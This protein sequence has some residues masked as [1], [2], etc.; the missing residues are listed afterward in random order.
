MMAKARDART[1]KKDA[2]V[3]LINQTAPIVNDGEQAVAVS[4]RGETAPSNG[5][6]HKPPGYENFNAVVDGPDVVAKSFSTADV[7]SGLKLLGSP[8]RDIQDIPILADFPDKQYL[9]ACA[10]VISRCRIYE[11]KEGEAEV[12]YIVTGMCG[13]GGKRADLI[14]KAIVG[15]TSTTHGISGEWGKF[16]EKFKQKIEGGQGG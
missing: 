11:D 10:R 7:T 15:D 2:G 9:V 14:V 13:I 8:G 5:N 6:G 3:A 16:K 12:L 4:L 1:A